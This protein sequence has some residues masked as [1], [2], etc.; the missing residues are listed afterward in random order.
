MDRDAFSRAVGE[1]FD[2]EWR[3]ARRKAVWIALMIGL[4]L[5]SAAG[6]TGGVYVTNLWGG[7]GV[8]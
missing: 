7:G 5:G 8:K 6:T 1:V 4:L 3:R 2:A